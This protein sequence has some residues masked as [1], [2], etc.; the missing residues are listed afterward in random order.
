MYLFVLSSGGMVV[1][2][3]KS[4]RRL[5]AVRP[6]APVSLLGILLASS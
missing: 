1:D 4:D 5:L 3:S 2:I 6:L